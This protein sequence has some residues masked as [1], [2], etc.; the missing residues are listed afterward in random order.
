MSFNVYLIFVIFYQKVNKFLEVFYIFWNTKMNIP[1][2][3]KFLF[4]CTDKKSFIVSCWWYIVTF[5]VIITHAFVWYLSL[6]ELFGDD[7]QITDGDNVIGTKGIDE[8]DQD[9]T[10]EQLAAMEDLDL[11]TGEW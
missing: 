1:Q 5:W 4:I 8:F 11:S 2:N 9:M 7:M 6:K 3:W 10:D